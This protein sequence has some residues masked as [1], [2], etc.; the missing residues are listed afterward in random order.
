M[1]DLARALLECSVPDKEKEAIKKL[2]PEIDL[3]D[4]NH[5][6]SLILAQVKK[7]R[8]GNTEA[9]KAV[10]DTAGYNPVIKNADTDT[11]G[12]DK[13]IIVASEKDKEA[14]S[15]LDSAFEDD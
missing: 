14:I 3:E 7:A 10:R 6:T 15:K 2:F 13:P 8:N 9:F 12:N 1:K 5:A 4:L 11:E